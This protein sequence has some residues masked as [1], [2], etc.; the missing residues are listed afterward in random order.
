MIVTLTFPVVPVQTASEFTAAWDEF[1]RA[2]RR[3]R[4]RAAGPL[5]GSG[6][7][8][9]QYQLL[10]GLRSAGELT[11]SELAVGAGVAAPTATRMLDGLVRDGQ[12]TRRTSDRDR[13]AVLIS[14]TEDGRA[15]VEDAA[16]R[17]EAARARVRDSL[18]PVEQEQA[19]ALL[20][21]LAAVVEERL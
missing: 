21:R 20:R 9:A 14:L 13:R 2:I 8:L 16:R 12:V 6:L 17:V 19:A 3:A 18:T 11:V 15:A 5:E 10:E 4:G 7:S 1:T